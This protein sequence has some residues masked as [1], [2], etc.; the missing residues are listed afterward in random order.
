MTTTEQIQ[1]GGEDE[2][3]AGR[4]WGTAESWVIGFG[5]GLVV[6]ALMGAA[7]SIGYNNGQESGPAAQPAA[8]KPKA[9][10]PAAA[11]PGKE[12]FA[13]SCGSCHTLADA[14]TTGTVGPD[15]D[16]LAPDAARVEAAIRNGGAGTGMMPP[17][18]YTG[19]QAKQVVAYV[20]AVAGQE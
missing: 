17:N 11:G 8:E 13:Q 1:A 2:N 14:G 19:E 3:G 10:P 9:E 15:L 6:L 4:R 16:T 18:L 5:A 12:L 7:Y 20:A